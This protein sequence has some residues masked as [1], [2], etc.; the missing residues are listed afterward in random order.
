MYHHDRRCT[1]DYSTQ[2]TQHPG[3]APARVDLRAAILAGRALPSARA[4]LATAWRLL[5]R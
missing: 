2:D 5:S 1:Q 3:A 4:A